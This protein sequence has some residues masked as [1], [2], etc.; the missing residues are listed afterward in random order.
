MTPQ[1]QEEA[2][3]SLE[4]V[5]PGRVKSRPHERLLYSYD[6][7]GFSSQPL[8]VLHLLSPEEA[9]KAVAWARENSASLVG[10][11]SGSGLSGGSVPG[12]GAVVLSFEKMR[13]VLAVDAQT[14][15]VLVQAGTIN[16]DLE[17]LLAPWGLFYPPDPAS[18]RVSTI[19]GNILENAGGPHALKYG[20]T[21]HH[22]ERL[23]IVDAFGELGPLAPSGEVQPSLDWVSLL[24]GSEGT[25]ALVTGATLRV[26]RMPAFTRTALVSFPSMQ[27]ATRF[28]SRVIESGILP[29]TLE[30]LDKN[31]IAAV[32][33]WG[34]ARYPEGAEAVLILEDDGEEASVLQDEEKIR[35][36]AQEEGALTY[37][38]ARDSAER[39][40]LWEGRRGAY[41]AVA[42]LGK[43][44]LTQDVTVPREHLTEMLERAEAIG[45]EAGFLVATVG[46]AGDGNLHP[47]FPYDP[48]NPEELARVHEAN[49]R[50]LE[51]AVRLGG[52]ISGEHG[53]GL[54]KLPH[55]P[56][57]FT[58]E[59]LGLMAEVKRALDPM[60][61]LNPGK[62][63][64]DVPRQVPEGEG[65]PIAA[66]KDG[67]E[68]REA[69]LFAARRKAP[70]RIDL[71]NLRGIHLDL[72]NMTVEV[73]AGESL[74]AVREALSRT[75]LHFPVTPAL[76]TGVTR[77]LFLNDYGPDHLASGTFRQV[78]LA[79]TYVTGAGEKVRMGRGVMK[80]VAG[81]DLFRPLIGSRGQMGVPISFT[82]RLL[83]NEAALWGERPVSPQE[84][85]ILPPGPRPASFFA[86]PELSGLQVFGAFRGG[87][88]QGWT[89]AP[90]AESLLDEALKDAGD[91]RSLLDLSFSP[92]KMAAVLG[93]LK[94]PPLLLFPAA[95]RIFA[96]VSVEEARHATR[97]A[98][99]PEGHPVRALYGKRRMPLHTLDPLTSAWEE[100]LLK[101]FDPFGILGSWLNPEEGFR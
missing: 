47:D 84:A 35:A 81:Y 2:L 73:G 49:A 82:F 72:P 94:E 92:D 4:A 74:Q 76:E 14:L 60:G 54:E 63:I 40:A 90:Q 12:P 5:F 57:M 68:V 86:L 15:R 87:L 44:V 31:T 71:Q 62:A 58:P 8:A 75:A 50:V 41:A 83:P 27:G 65:S 21:G 18:H 99:A 85:F 77:A 93:S 38:V 3:A 6:A 30:F 66:P 11:G 91:D 101:V 43:R 79:T 42:R 25:L 59:E 89:P 23:F 46:H 100:R 96:R 56:L 48:D 26:E 70:L 10:R 88:P 24:V 32:E 22:V 29:S 13:Q 51:T 95:S 34:V 37:L 33:A 7:S 67:D 55:L 97:V 64:L 78:L 9:Q 53:I 69:V 39:D 16:R 1:G 45:R 20:V 28:V 52:S 36:L 80:N 19:G 17:A 61:V 98:A